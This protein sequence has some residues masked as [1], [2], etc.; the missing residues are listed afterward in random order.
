MAA[1]TVGDLIDNL[2]VTLDLDDTD[3]IPDCLVIAKTVDADGQVSI[4]I[5][6]SES[7]TWLDQLGL[8]TAASDVARCGYMHQDED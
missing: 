3:I 8:L 4:A 1:R 2:G 6:A 5:G 7:L